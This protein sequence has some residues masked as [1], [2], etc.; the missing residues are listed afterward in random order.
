[1]HQLNNF[2][3]FWMFQA[4]SAGLSARKPPVVQVAP[5]YFTAH[6]VNRK[7]N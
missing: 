1:M 3:R 7:L 5:E 6:E 2:A 4:P